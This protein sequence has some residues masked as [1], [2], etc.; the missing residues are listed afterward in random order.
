[1]VESFVEAHS[2]FSKKL[3]GDEV[4]KM[5]EFKVIE[6]TALGPKKAGTPK[7][8]VVKEEVLAELGLAS[9]QPV[10]SA[11]ESSASAVSEE[12]E[13]VEAAFIEHHMLHI[14]VETVDIMVMV[15]FPFSMIW[16][17]QQLRA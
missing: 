8:W 9:E 2:E 10:A 17:I 5:S 12:V 7:K 3:V 6:A 16:Q 11:S 15:M 14:A 13:V 4:R 1:M